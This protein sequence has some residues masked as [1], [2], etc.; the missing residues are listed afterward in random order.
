MK[1]KTNTT[2][3]NFIKQTGLLTGGLAIASS[4]LL[5]ACAKNM[6]SQ[7]QISLAQWSVH[8]ALESGEITNL[9][10]AKIARTEFDISAV[11]Y[12][13]RGFV[14]WVKDTNYLNQMNQVAKDYGVKNLLVMVDDEGD[15]AHHDKAERNKTVENHYKWVEAA[16]HLGCHSIRVNAAGQG[17]PEE[18]KKNAIEGLISLSE[19]ASDYDINVI[20]E[21]HGGISS[22]GKWLSE[23]ISNVDMTNCGTLPDFGNFCITKDA[24]DNCTDEYDRYQGMK[25]LMPYAKGVSAKSHDFDENGDEINSDFAK[26]LKIVKSAGFK[27][28]IGIEYEGKNMSEY[29]GIRATK[30]LLERTIASL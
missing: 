26:M 14:K 27:G 9:D 30:A 1:I 24:N 3:R 10:F 29:E 7:F 2:R 20:V 8:K 15:L 28:Y 16:K 5:S 13:S 21:N 23:V 17:T 11:E 25:D 18:V 12:V 19:F 4:P 22:N 6:Q